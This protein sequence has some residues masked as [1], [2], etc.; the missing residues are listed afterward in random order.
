MTVGPRVQITA[1]ALDW[2]D[3]AECRGEDLILFFGI[4]GERQPEREIR[5]RKAKAVCMRCPVRAECLDYAV[6]R[7]E[8]SGLWGGL[9]E[10]E[11]AMERRRRQRRAN[12]A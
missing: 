5:E 12:A 2:M 6:S 9:N 4:D 3:A 8:K 11:R 10:D 7:P 1:T